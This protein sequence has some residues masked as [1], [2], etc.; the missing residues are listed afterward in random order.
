MSKTITTNSV[1]FR[2][3]FRSKRTTQQFCAAAEELQA[4]NF[5]DEADSVIA[6]FESRWS[7]ESKKVPTA[8]CS[9]WQAALAVLIDLALQGWHIEVQDKHVVVS[10]PTATGGDDERRRRQAQL[11][12]RRQEQLSRDSVFRFLVKMETPGAGIGQKTIRDLVLDGED[13]AESLETV[14]LDGK[15]PVCPSLVP[16]VAGQRCTETGFLLTDIWR[17]FRHTWT[18]P[19]ESVPGR[20]LLL[21]VRDTARPNHP[22]MGI[23]S[24]SSA[25][26]KQQRRDEYIGW[27][28][29]STTRLIKDN[30][31]RHWKAWVERTL[32]GLWEE[33]YLDDLLR[34]D[35]LP[36]ASL[37][38]AYLENTRRIKDEAIRCREQHQAEPNR[39]EFGATTPE[40]DAGWLDRAETPLFRSKRC[41]KITILIDLW[42]IHVRLA[43]DTT[44]S[45]ASHLAETTHGQRLLE[46]IVRLAKASQVGTA[47]A[48][49]SVCGA[50]PPYNE[51]V[52]G[53]LVALLAVS[54]DARKIY[55]ERY[56]EQPSIIAS[57]V[58]GKEIIRASDL[59]FVGTSSLYGVRPNQ[60]DRLSMPV[61]NR[62]QKDARLT[63]KHL[64]KSEGYGS[65]HIRQRTKTLLRDFAE[66]DGRTGWRANNIFGEGANPNMRALRESLGMLG[67]DANE[68][69]QH[70]QP[71]DMYGV[72]LAV[73][74]TEYLLG[75]DTKPDYL[76]KRG[77]SKS[78][79]YAISHYWWERWAAKRVNKLKVLERIREQSLAFP[80]QHNA[81]I[82][83][84]RPSVGTENMF[85]DL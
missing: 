59:V 7:P 20:S 27:T 65:V 81:I 34:D 84:P 38:S 16:V 66:A 75:L 17:Y 79:T 72:T 73:N 76:I 19:Y 45:Y 61:S 78:D 62:S 35:I 58:A 85:A 60:Y 28:L 77:R 44:R 10:R 69:L 74:A 37:A 11:S 32:L 47:I 43:T 9:A 56:R 68:L 14:K 48:D 83:P 31:R 21:L 51:L 50:I 3:V 71:R 15:L 82:N 39:A 52:V 25:S 6:G 80:I 29:S 46:Q 2:P 63:Y 18:T 33:T 30:P 41:E 13:F 70:S 5:F 8:D 49:L 67:L 12:V 53:K 40:S 22:I 55:R 36:A 24:L 54:H 57:S 4:I 26:V 1:P 23:A 42:A 64:G